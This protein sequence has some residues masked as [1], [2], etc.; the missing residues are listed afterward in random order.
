MYNRSPA[1][2]LALLIACLLFAQILFAQKRGNDTI[3]LSSVLSSLYNIQ[4]LP[5]YMPGT[6]SAQVSSYDTT[7][8]N[9]DGFSGKYSFIRRNADSSLVL[10]DVKGAGVINRIWTPTPNADTL[11]FFIDGNNTPA[12]SVTFEDLFSGKVQPF[13]S[14][15]CGNDLGGFYCYFPILFQKSCRIVGR[16]KKIQFHQIQYRLYPAGTTVESFSG[17]LISEE[18]RALGTVQRIWN[19]DDGSLQQL[20]WQPNTRP[21]ITKQ[22]ALKP[23]SVTEMY[24]SVMGGR[25]E[26]IEITNAAAFAGLNK[27]VDLEIIWDDDKVPAVNC[28]LADF[29]GYAFGKP[30][31]QSLL[32]GTRG[33]VNYCYIP[34]PFD[35]KATIRLRYRNPPLGSNASPIQI[36]TRI[37]VSNNKRNMATEGRFYTSWNRIAHQGQFHTFLNTRARGHYIGTILQAQGL[38]PGMTYFFEGDDSTSIDG[39][40]RLHGTGSEDYFNGGWYALTD[41]WDGKLSLPLHGCLDYSLPFCRTAAY[42]FYLS[43]KLNFET[44]IYHGIEHGS[45]GNQAPADYTSLGFYYADAGPGSAPSPA[46]ELTTVYVPDTLIMYPQLMYMTVSN[47]TAIHTAWAY[48]TGGLSYTFTASDPS[49]LKIDIA[50]LPLGKYRLLADFVRNAEGVSFSVWQ[51][52]HNISGWLNGNSV[53]EVIEKNFFIAGF[54]HTASRNSISIHFKT[55]PGKEKLILNRLIFV[56]N[57]YN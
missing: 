51:G 4:E 22:L 1:H 14:P 16:G 18:Q 17:K 26:A 10:F 38:V 53:Q 54:E 40:M 19:D 23:G 33:D 41:R 34:M 31:M 11:D 57:S 5:T 15:L 6:Y 20:Y 47:K 45:V 44:S 42:R 52:Q 35:R 21:V 29:F 43:D 37:Y 46:S 36:S 3:T 49:V 48:N 24:N 27:L 13:V 25:I 55:L 12:L 2:A 7:G 30:A 8:G 50:E 39:A 9:D 28:P 32:L 56:K